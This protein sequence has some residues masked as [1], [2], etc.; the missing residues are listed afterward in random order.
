MNKK[1]KIGVLGAF[2]GETMINFCKKTG[3]AQL[4]AVCDK[5][6]VA[7]KKVKKEKGVTCYNDFDEFI[8]HD[9][10]AVIL[11]NYANEHAWTETDVWFE[12][13][14]VFAKNY[15]RIYVD[16]KL[17]GTLVNTEW[18]NFD[19]D[20]NAYISS[21]GHKP[22]IKDMQFTTEELEQLPVWH[23][24][25]FTQTEENGEVIYSANHIGGAVAILNYAGVTG[26]NNSITFD[27][28]PGT[29]GSHNERNAGFIVLDRNNSET[30]LFFE[31]MP[32]RR[33]A[34]VRIVVGNTAVLSV[35][36]T[37]VNFNANQWSTVQCIFE[38]NRF[39]MYINGRLTLSAFDLEGYTFSDT[40][41]YMNAWDTAASYKNIAFE[42]VDKSNNE[43]GYGDFDFLDER[44]VESVTC[45]NANLTYNKNATILEIT[46][47]ETAIRLAI[48]DLEV[49]PEPDPDPDPNPDDSSSS[50][51][52]STDSSSEGSSSS[53]IVHE[54][55]N[56]NASLDVG[57]IATFIASLLSVAFI[58]R[59]KRK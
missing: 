11:A 19:S 20:V 16:G 48:E 35:K 17:M 14:C 15:A 12:V 1:I 9:M 52:N 59:V 8:K 33:E 13:K 3:E 50:V 51:D 28:K 7:L 27:I 54:K 42:K 24:S 2:R 5:Y 37:I 10:D 34:R 6:D 58:V 41:C 38:D 45:E 39:A 49:K 55:I 23:G 4:V 26:D 22:T 40:F 36:N 43:L 21:W 18:F 53:A 57:S 56:C 31:I 25:S 29:V 30:Y 32:E 44:G 46:G 47:A